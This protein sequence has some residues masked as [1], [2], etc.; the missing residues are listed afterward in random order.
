MWTQ[1]GHL[2]VAIAIIAT[3][4]IPSFHIKYST[5][6]KTCQQVGRPILSN[7]CTLEGG[8]SIFVQ[9][10]DIYVNWSWNKNLLLHFIKW[11][12]GQSERLS[13][14]CFLIFSINKITKRTCFLDVGHVLL[15][16][17]FNQNRF[18]R[19]IFQGDIL[20]SRLAP[21]TAKTH[22]T[23]VF[24]IYHS[25]NLQSPY[26]RGVWDSRGSSSS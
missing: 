18:D 6:D 10:S 5:S 25:S 15:V 9:I 7:I 21:A 3:I 17:D 16:S 22:S 19:F 26:F 11:W 4:A 14:I 24:L 12:R 20:S 2:T 23:N 1:T 8:E 13:T